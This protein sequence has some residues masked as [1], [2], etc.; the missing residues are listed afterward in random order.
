MCNLY[1]M[2]RVAKAVRRQFRISHNRSANFHPQPA[3]FPGYN[4]PIIRKAA[5]DEHELVTVS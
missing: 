1:S 2:S 4:A 5:D 3:I